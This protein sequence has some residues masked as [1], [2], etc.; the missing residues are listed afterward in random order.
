MTGPDSFYLT[1]MNFFHVKNKFLCLLHT[2]LLHDVLHGNIVFFDGFKAIK[3][4][5][6][7]NG[8]GIVMDKDER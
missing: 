7:I 3:A 8:N 6:G 5:G 2:V 4:V 1:N